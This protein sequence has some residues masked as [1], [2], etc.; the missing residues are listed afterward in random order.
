LRDTAIVNF[1]DRR[2]LTL[3]IQPPGTAPV[4]PMIVGHH[5]AD[6]RLLAIGLGIENCAA[7]GV[8]QET[9][10]HHPG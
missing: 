6:R 10:T 5:G 9:A 3:P 8:T 2:A 1:R 7:D 4:G